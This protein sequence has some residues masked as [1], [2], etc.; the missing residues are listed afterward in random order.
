M[1]NLFEHWS[2]HPISE[3]Q[4]TPPPAD[5]G[6][7]AAMPQEGNDITAFHKSSY[8]SCYDPRIPPGRRAV[9]NPKCYKSAIVLEISRPQ[10]DEA[11][12]PAD[13]LSTWSARGDRSIW[14]DLLQ[15]ES[16][17]GEFNRL[18]EQLAAAL[19]IRLELGN[20]RFS[21]LAL[22]FP[23]AFAACSCREF[24]FCVCILLAGLILARWLS[25]WTVRRL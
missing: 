14:P 24:H 13:L 16:F 3:F 17:L 2:I 19:L 9:M 11:E 25:A 15:G 12:Q 23:L 21:S 1:Q 4:I 20:P 5:T 6:R 10:G 8:R 22:Q 18:L 7:A